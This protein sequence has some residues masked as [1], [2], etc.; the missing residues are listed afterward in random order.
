MYTNI[1]TAH[2]L[3]V[4]TAWLDKLHREGKLP[5]GFPL[6]PVKEAMALVMLNNTFAW[7]DL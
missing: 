4:I 2:A 1:D 7:G 5:A 3:V 6:E